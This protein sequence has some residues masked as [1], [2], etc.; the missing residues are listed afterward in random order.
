MNI[1]FHARHAQG[2]FGLTSAVVLLALFVVLQVV[3][4]DFTLRL[5]THYFDLFSN[6][7][8]TR[9][10]DRILLVDAPTE[11]LRPKD[12]VAMPALIDKLAGLG[13]ES[14]ILA[15]TP[16]PEVNQRDVVQLQTLVQL[17]ER[18]QQYGVEVG[19]VTQ[20]SLRAE[21]DVL[22]AES[23]RQAALTDSVRR[24]GNVYLSIPVAAGVVS[25]QVPCAARMVAIPAGLRPFVT[26]SLRH[27][28]GKSLG[29]GA[30]RSRSRRWT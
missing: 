12:A 4:R 1:S 10:N 21:L 7:R 24:A 22:R 29:G 14:I 25:E 26:G 19:A 18:A 16:G 27:V 23:L 5:E 20:N 9:P 11:T 2:N 6:A 3:A 30:L 8:H 17:Q 28:G 15:M 13:T